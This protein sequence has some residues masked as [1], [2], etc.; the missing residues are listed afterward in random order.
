[1][2]L[3]CMFDYLFVSALEPVRPDQTVSGH[4]PA[5]KK[6]RNSLVETFEKSPLLTLLL[7]IKTKKSHIWATKLSHI[8][9]DFLQKLFFKKFA[10][11]LPVFNRFELCFCIQKSAIP[12][13]GFT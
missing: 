4:Q 6:T 9:G 8:W 3:R 1:M 12:L 13:M 5:R 11:F 2:V 10:I 7:V